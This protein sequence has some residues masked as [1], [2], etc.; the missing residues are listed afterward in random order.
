[1]PIAQG[2]ILKEKTIKHIAQ[3]YQKT[4]AQISLRWLVQKNII[5]IPRSTSEKH[6]QDNLNIFDFEI[7]DLDIKKINEVNQNKRTVFSP[8]ASS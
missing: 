4:P 7:A 1:M 8:W 2:L 6:L 3:K 5:A